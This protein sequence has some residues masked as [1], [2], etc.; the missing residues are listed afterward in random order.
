MK[1]EVQGAIVDGQVGCADPKLEKALKY[2]QLAL[3][4]V[5]AGRCNQKEM[6]V[7]AG[8]L[9]YL[10]TFRGNLMGCLNCIWGSLK[11]SISTLLW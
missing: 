4:T 7:I 1:A 10:A 5:I 3:L 6:Q 9:V 2:A 11:A 8:G